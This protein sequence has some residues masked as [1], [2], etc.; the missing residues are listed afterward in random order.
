VYFSGNASNDADAGF[1]YANSNHV[2]S[3]SN[4]NIGSH[5]CFAEAFNEP[6]LTKDG[7]PATWQKISSTQ[8]GASRN[9]PRIGYRKPQLRK[10]SK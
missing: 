3:N 5:L 2:P 8:N 7:N 6:K 9:A 1:A 10:Q 4:T